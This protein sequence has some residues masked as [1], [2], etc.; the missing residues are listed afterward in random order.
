VIR[1]GRAR[2]VDRLSAGKYRHVGR[3]FLDAADA[4]SVV[5]GDDETYGNAIGLLSIHAAIAYA[6][7]VS[8]AYGERKSAAGDHE[9]A[10]SMLRGVLAAR[11]PNDME[12]MLLT[13]VRAKDSVAYQGKYYPLDDGR[14]LLERATTFARWADQLYQQRP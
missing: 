9:Q 2:P 6:D 4:L 7:A 1:R 11:L 3:A 8:I 5:A 12:S 10:V 13:L 14:A